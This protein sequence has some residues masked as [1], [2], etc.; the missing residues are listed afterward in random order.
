MFNN[1]LHLPT[2]NLSKFNKGVYITGVKVFN[3]LLQYMKPLV[4]ELKCFK[5]KLSGFYVI[6]LSTQWMFIMNLKRFVECKP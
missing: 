5:S 4:N 1:N 6:I 2:V 3:H